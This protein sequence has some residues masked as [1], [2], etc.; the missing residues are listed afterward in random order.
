VLGADVS[1][2]GD[3]AGDNGADN[4][5]V[6]MVA[7]VGGMSLVPPPSAWC[8]G[9]TSGGCVHMDDVACPVRLSEPPEAFGELLRVSKS[10]C[11]PL[12]A[13][14]VVSAGLE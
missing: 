4:E 12:E 13:W 11:M 10:G 7:S 2:C 1:G 5:E 3:G 9:G 8:S 14:I 6:C